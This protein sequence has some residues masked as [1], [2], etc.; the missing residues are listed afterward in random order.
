MEH[1]RAAYKTGIMGED[2]MKKR[3]ACIFICIV[4]LLSVPSCSSKKEID[5]GFFSGN[6]NPFTVINTY[7][8][9]VTALTQST[10]YTEVIEDS[11]TLIL[12][13]AAT[14]GVGLADIYPT[15]SEDNTY[16]IYEI[17][18]ADDIYFSNGDPIT[19]KDVAFS[20][21][22]YADLDYYGWSNVG[23]SLID[24]LKNYQ[25][26]NSRANNVVIS[27][28]QIEF[29]LNNPSDAT[30]K[31]IREKVVLPV[32][33]E[34]YDWVTRL[35]TDDAFKG[36]EAEEHIKLY[37]EAND[38][39][40]FYY[41]TDKSYV[42]AK[43]KTQLINDIADQIGTDYKLLSTIYGSDLSYIAKKQVERALTEQELKNSGE[44]VNNISGIKIIDDKHLEVRIN[45]VSET[46][47]EMAFGFFVVPFSVYGKGSTFDGNGFV[48]DT[49]YVFD[50]SLKPVGAGP[51]VFEGYKSGKYVNLSENKHYYKET[52]F[53]PDVK[54]VETGNTNVSPDDKYFITTEDVFIAEFKK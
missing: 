52:T 19:A 12:Y 18:L 10:L 47:V 46:Q 45:T 5:F 23:A 17:T 1:D 3:I 8:Y 49:D 25:Y 28:D 39:F 16:R 22:V 38:L 24:G 43:N 37:P 42:A 20:M 4:I 31:Y 29:E 34:E 30:K 13:D 33:E 26:R 40:A 53:E 27:D 9:A 21:Y 14:Q 48:I 36:T 41:S 32:L 51:C 44:P 7:D 50:K 35:Y 6:F 54:L 15:N 2:G 11:D